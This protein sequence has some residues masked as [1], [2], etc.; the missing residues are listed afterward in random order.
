MMKTICNLS[1]VLACTSAFQFQPSSFAGRASSVCDRAELTN[2]LV[3][4]PSRSLGTKRGAMSMPPFLKKLGL[5]KP[6][7]TEPEPISS[8]VSIETNG[9]TSTSK[10]ELSGIDEAKI[11]LGLMEDPN[12]PEGEEPPSAMERVKTAGASGTIAY[13]G[14]ELIFWTVSVPAAVFSYHATTGEWLD[15]GSDEGRLKVFELSTAFL[16]FARLAV[17]LRIALAVASAPW[18]K[19]NVLPIFKK[20]E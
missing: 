16:T 19:N 1:I 11:I 7:K 20:E 15:L 3:C 10:V 6:E 14:W 17:P 5:K 12:I 18:V 13:A 8:S 9:Q 4:P 2:E